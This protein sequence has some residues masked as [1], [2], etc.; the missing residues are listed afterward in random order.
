M[1]VKQNIEQ[2][3][4]LLNVFRCTYGKIPLH[5][6]SAVHASTVLMD[7]NSGQLNTL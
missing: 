5:S 1:P 4:L 2:Y 6:Q 3:E 7:S